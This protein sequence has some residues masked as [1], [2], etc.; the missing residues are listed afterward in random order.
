MAIF[1]VTL[2][3]T[4][5]NQMTISRWNY[6]SSG[7][8]AAVSLSFALA[9]A[10]G[11]VFELAAIPPAYPADS[12]LGLISANMGDAWDWAQLTVLDPYSPTDFYQTPFIP[13]YGG[14]RAGEQMSP[15]VAFG[16]RT[17]Q[18]R[19]DVAR[20]TK[21]LPG[22]PES[23]VTTGGL[24][25]TAWLGSMED[26]AEKMSEILSYDDEGN[27]LTFSPAVCGKHQYDP[28][29][30][31]AT[32]NHR[33]YEYWETEAEQIAHTAVGVTWQPYTYVRT[34]VSRQYGHGR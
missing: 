30:P 13:A 18:V 1:E 5:F 11:G 20:G 2:Q 24:L 12:V 7:V 21:R 4:Y 26:I 3:G 34:Q 22:V 23:A 32:G 9:T 17:N 15:A 31:P 19:R 33:A 14:T 10:F 8:P 25:E 29:P 16:F 27:T 28:N 6:V